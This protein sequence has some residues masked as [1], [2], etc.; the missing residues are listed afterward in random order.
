MNI[1]IDH[2]K[3]LLL[4]CSKNDIR[5]YLNG[6]LIQGDKMVASD[7]HRL[8]VCHLEEDSGLNVII[9]DNDVAAAI[10]LVPRDC[11]YIEVTAEKIGRV[12]YTP[13]NGDYLNWRKVI[14][15]DIESME[16]R[17]V[18]F[19]AQTLSVFAKAAKMMRPRHDGYIVVRMKDE[20]SAA[21]VDFGFSDAF[22]ALMMPARNEVVPCVPKWLE[23]KEEKEEVRKAA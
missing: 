19:N 9:P 8:V 10:K 23:I 6:I 4:F 20:E 11:S 22:F 12:L 1:N 15:A 2:L 13:I 17:S 7:G 18:C 5:Y 3:V 21:I 14:P 16:V